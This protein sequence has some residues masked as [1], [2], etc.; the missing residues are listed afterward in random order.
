MS[1]LTLRCIKAGLVC[2]VLG[3]GLGASFAIDR[4]LGAALRP[5]HAELN[6]WGW[7]TLLIYGMAYHMMPRFSGQPLRRPRLAEAQSWLAIAGVA[8]ASVGWLAGTTDLS[9][10]IRAGG[11]VIQLIAA[12]LFAWMIGELLIPRVAAPAPHGRA[13]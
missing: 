1:R 13:T 5:L 12:I 10:L 2:L 7:V 4:S 8:L 6:L 11:G 3:I 9:L